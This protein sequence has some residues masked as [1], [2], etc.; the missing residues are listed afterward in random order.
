MV[1][2]GLSGFLEGS[3]RVS[4]RVLSLDFWLVV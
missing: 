4:S 1:S 3:I 2:E